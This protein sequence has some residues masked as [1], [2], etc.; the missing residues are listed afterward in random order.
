M[1]ILHLTTFLEGGAG[2]ILTAL[3]IEQ[4]RAGHEVMV[5]ADVGQDQG[6]KGEAHGSQVH[7]TALAR[8]GVEFHMVSSTFKRDLVL[9][10]QA[11]K[12]V[13][14]LVGAR[15]IDVAHAHAAIPAMVA[16]LALGRSRRPVPIV[17]TLH[18][19]RSARTRQEK[20]VDLTLLDL[21]DTV[22]TTS[23]AARHALW[24]HGL[25]DTPVHVVPY[26]IE[27][28]G[29]GDP[30]DAADVDTLT[31]LREAGATLAVCSGTVGQ[32]RGP[33][34]V[35]E[36]LRHE[37]LESLHVVFIGDGD[38][39]SLLD[40][41]QAGGVADRVHVLGYRQDASR[42]LTWADVLVVPSRRE[43]LPLAVLEAFRDSVPV[44]AT[45]IPEIAEAIDDGRTGYLFDDGSALAL[46]AA[47]ERALGATADQAQAMR[48]CM[49]TLFDGRYSIDRMIASH[50]RVY[51][52][53]I[54]SVWGVHIGGAGH[55]L[56]AGLDIPGAAKL[57]A[58]VRKESGVRS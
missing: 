44:V 46:R 13:R 24:R 41:A 58:F 28:R 9:N 18:R 12:Q 33:S 40:R 52:E 50:E 34:L 6:S 11:V 10:V 4:R 55:E 49:R 35:L 39:A 38:A 21:V 26:G 16:R 32:G 56:P 30:I 27:E 15:Q 1:R 2:R 57:A 14:A 17:T 7:E 3:A 51:T 43:G 54:R 37:S 48:L 29:N 45:A 47:L 22:I 20:Y 53:S 31:R 36:A 42:Y 23:S 19:W 8:A 25:A 5:V